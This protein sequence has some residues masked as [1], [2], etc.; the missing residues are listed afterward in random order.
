MF[1]AGWSCFKFSRLGQPLDFCEKPSQTWILSII[2][3]QHEKCHYGWC[4]SFCLKWQYF[5]NTFPGPH[6]DEMFFDL[7]A[8][9]ITLQSKLFTFNRFVNAVCLP[10]KFD[11][12][13]ESWD[14][15]I[16]TI[17]GF[18]RIT[19]NDFPTKLQIGQKSKYVQLSI[20]LKNT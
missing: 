6:A 7:D 12:I 14:G 4:L 11:Q 3:S 13:D 17:A 8:A 5:Y 2:A 20:S 1:Q 9:L 16:F 10:N 15:E 19:N 18:G